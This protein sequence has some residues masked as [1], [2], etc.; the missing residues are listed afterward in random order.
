MRLRM[1]SVSMMRM[2]T[3]LRQDVRYLYVELGG[4]NH[5]RVNV[6]AR[7]ENFLS[8]FI[9]VLFFFKERK[10]LERLTMCI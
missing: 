5:G 9:L 2:L 1:E 10:Y 3:L 7:F 8:L 4:S 6:V